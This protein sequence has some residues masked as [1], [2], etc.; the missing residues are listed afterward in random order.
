MPTLTIKQAA[1]YFGKNGPLAVKMREGAAKG[2]LSAAL[3]A[4][5]Q[6]VT[7]EIPAK[8]PPPID[9]RVYAAGWAVEKLPKGA[10]IYNPVL[11]AAAIEDG[12]PAGN[13]VLSTKMQIALAEWAQRK[14]LS[15]RRGKP[16]K[17]G[18]TGGG[19][20]PP[21]NRTGV[22]RDPAAARLRAVHP[23]AWEIAG[24]I[25][26]SLK[27]RGIFNRGAGLK[28][29]ATFAERSLPAIMREEVEKELQRVTR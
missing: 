24:A 1:N 18:A 9:R 16:L 8:T 13:V 28:V 10:A 29:L 14:G 7:R 12:V 27:K 19:Q 11:Y 26:K 5:Q 3:R 25:M 4:K 6:I 23:E 2:L 15:A 22:A 17:A 20:R 21:V